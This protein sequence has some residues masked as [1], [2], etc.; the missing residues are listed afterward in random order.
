MQRAFKFAI[1]AKESVK[2]LG[3]VYSSLRNGKRRVDA[4][5]SFVEGLDSAQ[6]LFR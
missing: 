4:W 2:F 3:F 6:V 5:S 1:F